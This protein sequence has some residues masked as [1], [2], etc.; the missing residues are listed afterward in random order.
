MHVDRPLRRSGFRRIQI[1]G[2]VIVLAFGFGGCDEQESGGGAVA[3]VPTA[4]SSLPTITASIKPGIAP[5]IGGFAC[6]GGPIASTFQI[7]ISAS[8]TIDLDRVSIQMIDGSH[9]GGP[10]VTFPSPLL[11]SQ[12]SSRRILAGTTRAFAFRPQF[13]CGAARPQAVSAQIFYM[14]PSGVIQ[15]ITIEQ[16]L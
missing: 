2:F 10:M 3:F 5:G 8:Q 1:L 15:D 12:F 6:P 7:V 9:L 14:S 16:P 4:S 11:T 13:V